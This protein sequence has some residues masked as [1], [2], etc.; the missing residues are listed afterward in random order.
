MHVYCF[1]GL[2]AS[3]DVFKIEELKRARLGCKCYSP[4]ERLVVQNVIWMC[5]LII[6]HH[7]FARISCWYKE[8]F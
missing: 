4:I 8:N 6:M 3:E 2:G 7:L 1:E 5:V